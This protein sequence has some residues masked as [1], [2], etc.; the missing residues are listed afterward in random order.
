MKTWV[1][2]PEKSRISLI[3]N[4][5]VSVYFLRE[6]NYQNLVFYFA[7]IWEDFI[8]SVPHELVA[9]L[10]KGQLKSSSKSFKIIRQDFSNRLVITVILCCTSWVNR[11]LSSFH[12]FRTGCV[13]IAL[14]HILLPA[15]TSTISALN[16]SKTLFVYEQQRFGLKKII[17]WLF[18]IFPLK[19]YVSLMSTVAIFSYYA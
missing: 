13:S 15:S 17:Q 2:F 9:F 4:F 12:Q 16:S 18:F 1:G 11:I 19:L 14:Q 6:I 3:V 7:S 8:S 10:L 5:Q